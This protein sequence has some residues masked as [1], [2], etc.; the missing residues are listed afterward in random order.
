M[1]IE[2]CIMRIHFLVICICEIILLSTAESLGVAD[3]QFPSKFSTMY[4]P[5]FRPEK[6][7]SGRNSRSDN[8]HTKLPYSEAS[9]EKSKMLNFMETIRTNASVRNNSCTKSLSLQIITLDDFDYKFSLSSYQRYTKQVEKGK[10]LSKYLTNLFSRYP[11]IELRSFNDSHVPAVVSVL[12]VI[13]EEDVYIAGA[14]IAFTTEFFPYIYKRE[15]NSLAHEE[16]YGRAYENFT[17]YG[18]FS[19]HSRR[20]SFG[21]KLNDLLFWEQPYFDCFRLKRWVAGLSLPFFKNT[22]GSPEFRYVL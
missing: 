21:K 3:V 19:I 14:G 18:F 6:T 16:D 12:R 7:H 13:I 4:H 2:T 20:T 8:F 22:T 5:N 1:E 11:D 15:D 17:H 10:F 9:I